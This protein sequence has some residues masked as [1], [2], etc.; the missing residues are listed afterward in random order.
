[1]WAG[2]IS[3]PLTIIVVW[4]KSDLHMPSPCRRN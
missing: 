2:W 1:M 4:K 3:I